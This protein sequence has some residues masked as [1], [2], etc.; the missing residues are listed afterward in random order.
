MEKQ[1]S[2]FWKLPY[3]LVNWDAARWPFVASVIRF[4][5]FRTTWSNFCSNYSWSLHLVLQR[6]AM[7]GPFIEVGKDSENFLSPAAQMCLCIK[8][9]KCKFGKSKSKQVRLL[10]NK[11][12]AKSSEI[13]G[14]ILPWSKIWYR[15]VCDHISECQ[16]KYRQILTVVVSLTPFSV[17]LKWLKRANAVLSILLNY[18]SAL[19][20]NNLPRTKPFSSR[21]EVFASVIKLG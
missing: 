14:S 19:K 2:L 1:L 13:T 3:S 21:W 5:S 10:F 16:F 15:L 17:A 9:S 20:G 12:D 6:W 4:C 11:S 18:L 7:L 8:V